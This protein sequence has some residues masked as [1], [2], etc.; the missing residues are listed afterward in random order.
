M[1]VAYIMGDN[2]DIIEMDCTQKVDKRRMARATQS[3][4]MSRKLATDA[5]IS[6]NPIVQLEGIVTTV[7]TKN[8]SSRAP[9][10]LAFE[11][12][13]NKLMEDQVI[14]R[15]Y[16]DERLGR[17]MD[18]ML[19]IDYGIS[20]DTTSISSVKVSLTMQQA[21]ITKTA[22]RA[23]IPNNSSKAQLSNEAKVKTGSKTVKKVEEKDKTFFEGIA[24]SIS[25]LLGG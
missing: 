17:T 7:V 18:D 13:L 22:K 5:L 24:S 8:P 3:S 6:G 19:L 11:D 2:N 1:A 12:Y 16:R 10:P 23:F 21:F 9:D 25:G 15:L 14:F 4:V 20:Q